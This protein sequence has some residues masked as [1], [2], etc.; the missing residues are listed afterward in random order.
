MAIK[1]WRDFVKLESAGGILLFAAAVLAIIC[2]NSPLSR[3]YADL[4]SINMR[5]QLGTF[6]LSKPLLL[7]VNDGLMTIFFF[8][9]GLEIKRELYQGELNSFKKTILPGIAAAGG[10]A[11]PAG[12]YLL[13]NAGNALS[14]QG[15]AIPAATDIAFSLGVLALLGSRVPASLKVFLMAVAIFDD[16]GAIAIIAIFYTSE[17]MITP[18]IAS[19][20]LSLV[21]LLLNR[22]N[23]VKTWPYLLVGLLLWVCVLKSGIHATLAGIVLAFA[24]PLH[25]KKNPA[26]SPLRRIERTLHPWVVFGVL[27][28]FA[29]ANAG[30][31]IG[32]L[33]WADFLSPVTI[34][35]AAGLF[36]G[37]QLGVFLG[38]WLTIRLGLAALPRGTTL[39][40]I[41]GVALISGIG[42]TMSL[43]IGSLA[44]DDR[45][46]ESYAEFVRLG[47]LIGSFLSGILGFL[48][49]R[50][51]RIRK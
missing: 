47:V 37:K 5:F 10:M 34:G 38:S 44:F 46:A 8:V 14:L 4:L 41:Y 32:G 21:L 16:I 43:F 11:F 7:W 45:H 29:F 28:V 19:I 1:D 49:L 6:A 25:N 36:V 12:I 42:F 20:V 26:N 9:V 13:L 22:L 17:V 48:M 30:I 27:P 51:G 40:G 2:D 15:W 31:S 35:I 18:I 50:F 23:V 3:Y 39:S 24:I 33:Q